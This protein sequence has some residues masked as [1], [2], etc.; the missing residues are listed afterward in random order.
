MCGFYIHSDA[1]LASESQLRKML[2]SSGSCL[3]TQNH[4]CWG[5]YFMNET[6]PIRFTDGLSTETRSWGATDERSQNAN[7]ACST[8]RWSGLQT[9]S[10]PDFS[11]SEGTRRNISLY[12][13]HLPLPIEVLLSLLGGKMPSYPAFTA[14]ECA[15]LHFAKQA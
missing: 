15:I 12:N 9:L 8:G 1:S 5:L 4:R 14:F 6:F 10:E 11:W 13:L 3:L 7:G 2:T